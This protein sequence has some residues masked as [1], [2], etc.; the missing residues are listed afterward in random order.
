MNPRLTLARRRALHPGYVRATAA[1][2]DT[3]AEIYAY[4]AAARREAAKAWRAPKVPATP[5]A[6]EPVPSLRWLPAAYGVV[7]LAVWAAAANI[8]PGA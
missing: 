2:L 3:P 1:K 5:S 4:P 8:T 6:P 7:L